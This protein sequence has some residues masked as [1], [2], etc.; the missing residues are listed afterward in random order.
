[1][2]ISTVLWAFIEDEEGIKKYFKNDS[3][4]I[5]KNGKS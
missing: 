2:S 3:V 4:W 1:M 5:K